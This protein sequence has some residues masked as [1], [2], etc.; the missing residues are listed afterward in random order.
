MKG[1]I[2][3]SD[4]PGNYFKTDQL[5]TNGK[6]SLGISPDASVSSK[7]SVDF[8]PRPISKTF[9]STHGGGALF[10]ARSQSM[11]KSGERR[12]EVHSRF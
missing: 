10:E 2:V 9:K 8:G 6:L 11:T 7:P 12:H 4:E 1:Q 3:G 5:M